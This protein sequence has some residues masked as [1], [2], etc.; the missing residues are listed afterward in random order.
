MDFNTYTCEK[1]IWHDACNEDCIC[2]D[3]S[4]SEEYIDEL[5]EFKRKDFHN[6]WKQYISYWE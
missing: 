6:E 1:C 5:I 3:F 4:P 2:E